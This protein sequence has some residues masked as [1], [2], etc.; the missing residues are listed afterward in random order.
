MNHMEKK[1][2]VDSFDTIL[3]KLKAFGST[4]EKESKSE[5]YYTHQP[6]NDVVK[7]VVHTGKAEIHKLKEHDGKFTLTDTIPLTN[8]KAGM[9]W[10][11]QHGYTTL[12]VVKMSHVDYPYKGGIVGVYTINDF[13]RSVILDNLAGQHEAIE[14]E[15]GLQAAERIDVPYNKYLESIGKL[16]QIDLG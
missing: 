4:P 16:R 10:L 11:K 12:D 9:S 1:Y 5:H 3:Q 2:R 8:T 7:L 13:L 14:A 15:L 6:N